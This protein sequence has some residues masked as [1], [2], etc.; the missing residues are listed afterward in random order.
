M[1]A[2]K[3]RPLPRSSVAP[4]LRRT[5]PSP[6]RKLKGDKAIPYPRDLN[7]QNAYVSPTFCT[8]CRT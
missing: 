1:L 8:M 6:S 4:A 2:G 5:D 3:R 7:V